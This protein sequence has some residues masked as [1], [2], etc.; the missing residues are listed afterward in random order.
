MRNSWS[1]TRLAT[2]LAVAINL[3]GCIDSVGITPQAK[4][5][6]NSDLLTD[7]AIHHA[8]HTAHEEHGGGH[9]AKAD[10]PARQWWQAY[11]DPQLNAWIE[12]ALVNSPDLAQA[13]AR[14]RMAQAMAG[15]AESAELPQVGLSA[16]IQRKRL[17]NDRYYGPPVLNRHVWNNSSSLQLVYDLDIWGGLRNRE[18]QALDKAK[19]AVVEE[20]AAALELAGNIVNSYIQLALHYQEKDIIENTLK[21]RE[22]LLSMAERRLRHGLGTHLEVNEA[23]APIPDVLRQ[24]DD[25]EEAIKLAANQLAALA[26]K[27]PGEG[28]KLQRPKLS[29]HAEPSLPANLPL[30]LLGQRPDVIASLWQIA[31]EARGIEVAKADFY[32][33][34]NLLANLGSQTIEGGMLHFLEWHS[35]LYT[36]GAALNLPVFDGGRRRGT[37]SAVT[38]SY[39]LAVEHYNQ[40]LVMALKSVSD[41]LVHL[42]SLHEQHEFVDQALEIAERRF[43]LAENAYGRGLVDYRRVLEAQTELFH[44]QHLREQ[45]HAAQL[46]TQ[47]GLWVNLGGGMLGADSSPEQQTLTPREVAL[48]GLAK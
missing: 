27:G 38:A 28:D 4:V 40:T 21:Q 36:F 45:V 46:A 43:S 19:V 7:E 9:K 26:G 22:E 25:A 3:T 10:W 1:V 5:L 8:A 44:Q 41:H 12:Q 42:H 34:I 16:E 20:R 17:S 32:P 15:V 31:A 33:N 47:A 14:V 2:L 30:A 13:H 39:D 37:L 35:L 6:Q 24:L 11:H 29:L 23:K 48:R 18:E